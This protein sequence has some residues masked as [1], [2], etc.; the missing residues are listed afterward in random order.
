MEDALDWESNNDNLPFHKHMI[1]GSVAGLME[2]S[3][4][5][6]MDTIKTLAQ[7][8]STRLSSVTELRSV[9]G[10]FGIQRL[11]RGLSSIAM[12]CIPAHAAYFSIYE[13]SKHY[14]GISDHNFHVLAP[15]AVGALAV[16]SHDLI[17]TPMDG[18]I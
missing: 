16:I 13:S 2:H 9:V 6:P 3:S 11:W 8:E 12:G 18:K 17:M 15:M 10:E 5:F 7:A 14:M 4:S 1:A